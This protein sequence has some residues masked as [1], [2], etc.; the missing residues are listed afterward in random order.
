MSK[1]FEDITV[2]DLSQ[3]LAGPSC[4]MQLALLGADIIKIEP[5]KG[6]DQMRN[7]VLESQ[8]SSVGMAAG[9]LAMNIGK[10]SIALDIKNTRGREILFGLIKKSDVILHNFRAGVVDRLGLDYDSVRA[11][12]PDII[13]TVISGFGSE[14]PKSGDPAY[15]GAIQAAAG[16]MSNNGTEE[17]GP[18]RTGYMPV[19]LMTGMTAAYATTAALLRKQRTGKGQMVD[20]AMLDCAIVLQAANFA[21]CIVDN[22]PDM[23]IGNQSVTSVPT[24]SS[25][26]TAEGSILTAAIMPNHVEAF[27]EELGI[28]HMLQDPKFAT[29]EARIENK[30]IVREAMIQALQSDTAE[31]WEKR[32]APRGVPVAKINSVEE[33][34]KLEQLK[35]RNVLTDVPAAAGMEEGYKLVGAPYRNSEDGPE[36]LRAPPVLGQHSREILK[37]LGLDDMAVEELLEDGIVCEN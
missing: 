15:D 17:S 12:K 1:A 10:R 14:G 28:S 7:R 4:G 21:R 34:S 6:G 11:A 19:D 30:E 3:V 36:V 2:L 8:F 5:P 9:F 31:N 23:L 33:A 26:P 25:F 22:V 24:A 32:L 29:R 20:V 16:M 18:L 35:Y 27:F 13:Y 37:G